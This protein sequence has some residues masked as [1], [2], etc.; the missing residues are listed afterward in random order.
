[1]VWLVSPKLEPWKALLPSEATFET[2][3]EAPR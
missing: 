3:L 2:R 1:M